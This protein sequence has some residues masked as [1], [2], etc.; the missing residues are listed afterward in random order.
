MPRLMKE[1]ELQLKALCT[2]VST[3]S[4]YDKKNERRDILRQILKQD[5]SDIA[6]E[7]VEWLKGIDLEFILG[8][9]TLEKLLRML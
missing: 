9:Y 8:P 1:E 5:F 3:T 2:D 7:F 4:E 6:P